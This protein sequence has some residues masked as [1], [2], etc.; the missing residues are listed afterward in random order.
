MTS[1]KILFLLSS[2]IFFDPRILSAEEE[3]ISVILFYNQSRFNITST[4]KSTYGTSAFGGESDNYVGNGYGLLYEKPLKNQW[5]FETGFA[6]FSRGSIS[7]G[8]T[9]LDRSTTK[10]NSLYIPLVGRFRP[11][12]TFTGVIGVYGSYAIGKITTTSQ[13]SYSTSPTTTVSEFRDLGL[14]PFEGGLTYGAGVNWH[15]NNSTTMILEVRLNEGLS[16]IMDPTINTQNNNNSSSSTT[17]N[18][19]YMRETW[20]IVGFLI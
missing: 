18:K 15:I 2:L 14:K 4:N 13:T 9:S 17:E 3:N 1:K 5:S 7:K 16:N 19:A 6:Y 11:N 20:L 10:W 8:N 12:K